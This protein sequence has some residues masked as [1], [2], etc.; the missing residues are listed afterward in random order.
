M[1][2]RRAYWKWAP[3][4]DRTCRRRK[5]GVEAP[6][7]DARGRTSREAFQDLSTDDKLS[8]ST[9]RV[10]HNPCRKTV[11]SVLNWKATRQQ[12]LRHSTDV[13]CAYIA[14]LRLNFT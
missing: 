7:H 6:G 2:V 9:P 8:R 13:L 3:L 5:G 12:G 1:I 11:S 4:S 14:S 10:R